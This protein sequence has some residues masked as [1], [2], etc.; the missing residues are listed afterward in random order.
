MISASLPFLV[1][2]LAVL[3]GREASAVD[4]AEGDAAFEPTTASQ[5]QYQ[6]TQ[7]D[8]KRFELGLGFGYM[9][10]D[11]KEKI[12][13]PGKSNESGALPLMRIDG[14]Y[15]LGVHPHSP[16]LYAE[17]QTASGQLRYDGSY[18]NDSGEYLR[19]AT[20]KTP[21]NMTDYHLVYV[22]NFS[23][24]GFRGALDG[25]FGY[26]HHHW[27]RGTDGIPGG[28]DVDYNWSYIPIGIRYEL[29]QDANWFIQGKVELKFTFDGIAKTMKSQVDPGYSD[30]K[31]PLGSGTAFRVELPVVRILGE[32]WKLRLAP[33]YE[34]INIGRGKFTQSVYKGQPVEEDGYMVG[35]YEPASRTHIF[36]SD[37]SLMVAF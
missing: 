17:F 4:L 21:T 16:S 36:G 32:T 2:C 7:S 3:T 29:Y 8:G 20:A 24:Y 37:L 22:H 19:D 14:E 12:D 31:L 23:A 26:G 28:Y 9:N 25:Y 15:R 34:Q 35:S 6:S 10:F 27:F 18:Q 33:F 11:F 13:G 30:K 1:I 5:V